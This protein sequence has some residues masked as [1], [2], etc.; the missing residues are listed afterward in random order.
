[1]NS[2]FKSKLSGERLRGLL[3]RQTNTPGNPKVKPP[4]NDKWYIDWDF[5]ELHGISWD[6]TIKLRV[7]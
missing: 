2:Y 6:L 5:M 1:M 4:K 7:I 3:R